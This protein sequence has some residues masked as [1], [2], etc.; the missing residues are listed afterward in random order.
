MAKSGGDVTVTVIVRVAVKLPEVPLTVNCVAPIAAELAAVSVS[1]LVA[2]VLAGLNEA[3]RPAGKP[4]A[5][6]AT[7]PLKLPCCATLMVVVAVLPTATVTLAAEEES[8]KPGGAATVR[9]TVAFA[10][11]LPDVAVTV[12]VAGPAVADA[13][14]VSVSVL[15]ELMLA[16]LNAAVTPAGNPLTVRL[17]VPVKPFSGV[18]VMAL[19]A[20]APGVTLKVAGAAANVKPGAPF[21]VRLSVTVAD[22]VPEVPVTVTV[23]VPAVAEGVAL[24]VSVLDA[25]EAAGLND[26]VTPA[27]IPLTARLAVPVK[28]FSGVSVMV[29]L[30]D[31]PCETLTV[32]GT[33]ANVKPG[34]PFT[35]R[36]MVT[37]ADNVP[38]VPVTVTVVVPAVAVG[39][40]LSVRVTAAAFAVGLKEAV[41]PV[42]NPLTATPTVPVKPFSGVTVMVLAADAPCTTLR[43]AGAAANVKPVAPFT[44]RLSVTVADNVPEVPVTVTVVV[45]AAA[46]G[47]ALNV[48]VL[49]AAVV[50][51]LNDAVT[52][53]GRPEAVS[54]TLLLKPFFGV[55]VTVSVALAPCTTLTLEGE[56]ANEKPVV[57]VTVKEMETVAL[58]VPE[59]PVTVTVAAPT[60]ALAL[61]TKLNVLAVAVAAGLNDA[62][63]PLGNPETL[64]FTVLLNP[65]VGATVMAAVPAPPCATL[66]AAADVFRL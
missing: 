50:A 62:V 19:L 64:R 66:T 41:T 30:A 44:V 6:R 11:T 23:V 52:P 21:T 46:E 55:T 57:A 10:E 7:A 24:N 32:A 17:A 65:F 43:V 38:E 37:V 61:A 26:A 4:V 54:A 36:L 15:V 9:E 20:D 13:A 29:L 60:A 47:V 48:T 22:S 1:V 33:A 40:A 5:V 2:F 53:L 28:P 34:A 51:G 27:G 3:V 39:F 31:A 12:T 56:A 18:S 58:R 42:G 49:A 59:L 63:T 45:P 8:L 35:V 25:A 16:G 14:A